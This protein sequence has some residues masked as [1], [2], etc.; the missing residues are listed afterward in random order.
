MVPNSVPG[1]IQAKMSHSYTVQISGYNLPRNSF[2][3][4]MSLLKAAPFL[5]AYICLLLPPANYNFFQTC[6]LSPTNLSIFNIPYCPHLVQLI[7]IVRTSNS[8]QPV[9]CNGYAFLFSLHTL[10]LGLLGRYVSWLRRWVCDLGGTWARILITTV[11]F[12][13]VAIHFPTV[14][15]LQ[16]HQRSV[17]LTSCLYGVGG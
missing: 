10:L 15:N 11:T 4:N 3:Q 6:F 7:T 13:C 1:Y 14:Y 12:S 2:N 8:H 17:P 5:M 9:T 16:H